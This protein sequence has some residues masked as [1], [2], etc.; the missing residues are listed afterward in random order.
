[1]RGRVITIILLVGIGL[2]S[3]SL[4]SSLARYNLPGNNQGYRPVQPIGYSHRIHAGKLAVPC[5]YCHPGAERSRRAGIPSANI[6]MNCHRFV[7]ASLGAV[8]EEDRLAEEEGRDPRLIVSPEL[9]KLY[10]AVG[11]DEQ[12]AANPSAPARPL[13]WVRV[14]KLP[15]FVAFDHR[16]HVTAGVACQRCHGPVEG[17]DRIRQFPDMTMGWCV[18]CHRESGG[19]RL[20]GR[21]V[22]PSLDCA[23]CHY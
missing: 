2:V 20:A 15:D 5:L 23:T 6:C 11:L 18:S 21:P 16:P 19:T 1:M 7:T 12:L 10:D 8:R 22:D 3:V 13:E 14:Y 17:M 9:R 4:F